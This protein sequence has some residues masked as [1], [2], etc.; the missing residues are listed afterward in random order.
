MN[1]Y[2]ELSWEFGVRPATICSALFSIGG[3]HDIL[4]M[5]I[6][7]LHRLIAVTY[8]WCIV[9]EKMREMQL[10]KALGRPL[11]KVGFILRRSSCA[12]ATL[13]KGA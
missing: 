2:S 1:S 5:A 11:K 7:A 13:P 6:V 8:T 9:R 3:S 12:A 4:A 10:A